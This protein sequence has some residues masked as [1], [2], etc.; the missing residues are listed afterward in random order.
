MARAALI[1]AGRPDLAVSVNENRIGFP[2][3]A[4]LERDR[5]VIVKAFW[6]GHITRHP[7]ARIGYDK[8]TNGPCIECLDCEGRW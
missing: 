4:S 5:P 3:M 6:L 8:P 7:G 2:T 1:E